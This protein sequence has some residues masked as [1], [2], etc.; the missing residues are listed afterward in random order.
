M[1][2]VLI[3]SNKPL[4]SKKE[5]STLAKEGLQI[6]NSSK[7]SLFSEQ[8]IRTHKLDYNVIVIDDSLRGVDPYE[9]CCKLRDASKSTIILLGKRLSTEMWDKCKEIGF[10]QYYKKPLSSSKLA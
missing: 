10:D 9:T 2:T 3:L 7:Y 4:L 5:E 1:S 6:T 8:S